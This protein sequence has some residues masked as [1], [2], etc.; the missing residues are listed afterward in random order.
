M[1]KSQTCDFFSFNGKV[2]GLKLI[3]SFFSTTCDFM[4]YS[5]GLEGDTCCDAFF[6]VLKYLHVIIAFSF[7]EV[8]F[9]PFPHSLQLFL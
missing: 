6:Y 1:G 7:L 2:V 8:V 3:R 4:L 5:M 9:I